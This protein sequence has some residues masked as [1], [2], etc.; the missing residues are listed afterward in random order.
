M[1]DATVRF[2]YDGTALNAGL[3]ASEQRLAKFGTSAEQQFSRAN[4]ASQKLGQSGKKGFTGFGNASMQIQDIAVQ[5]QSGT[6]ASIIFAQQGSQLLSAFGPL[7][8]IAGAAAAVGGALYLMGE[9]SK[10]SFKNSIEGATLFREQLKLIIAEGTID[11]IVSSVAQ[12]Q[13][14]TKSTREEMGKFQTM[15]GMLSAKLAEWMGDKSP[16][17]KIRELRKLQ[18]ENDAAYGQV[19]ESALKDGAQQVKIAELRLRGENDVADAM[20]RQTK[21]AREVAQIA[22]R[23]LPQ[24]AKDEMKGFAD[25]KAAIA[26]SAA[27]NAQRE[28]ARAAQDELSKKREMIALSAKDV[29]LQEAAAKG[30]DR[31][32]K[33]MQEQAFIEKRA[34]DFSEQGLDA[35]ASIALAKRE[36]KAKEDMDDFQR[37]G[38]AKIGGGKPGKSRMMTSGIDRFN[39][40]Q[41]KDEQ[42]FNESRELGR[43]RGSLVS[44]HRAFD[45]APTKGRMMGGGSR[46]S[47]WGRSDGAAG[48]SSAS[49]DATTAAAMV[50]GGDDALD[51]L[52][53]LIEENNRILKEGLLS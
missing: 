9:K 22:A 47:L 43:G 20:E 30:Q 33:K 13:V 46:G 4:R 25:S 21:H 42:R 5:M 12:I 44:R 51:S 2:G 3:A 34:H 6:K 1:N 28:K 16:D 38:R 52:P 11:N 18:A 7:G 10:E 48:G 45:D 23:K 40:L 29:E 17:E 37:T 24:Y 26:D 15:G 32:V 31:K 53:A 36:W 39:R 14:Q 35:E 8:M 50:R 27:A 49:R 19:I 41:Q